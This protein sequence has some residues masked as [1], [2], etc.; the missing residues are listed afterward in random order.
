MNH[1]IT[2]ADIAHRPTDAFRDFLEGEVGRAFRQDRT[3]RR[4]RLA[5][6]ILV[7]LAIGTTAGL[8][9]AQVR[10]G[11]QRDSLL[12]AMRAE[13]ALVSLR[14][15]LSR[16][17]LAEQRRGVAAGTTSSESLT[18]ADLQVRDMESQLGRVALSMDEIKA[19]AK[20]PRDELNAPLVNGR[21]FVKERMQARAMILQPRM[22]AAEVVQA[23][24]A[25]RVRAGVLGETANQEAEL[26]LARAT[27]DLAVLAERLT[28]RKEYLEKGTPVEQ[29]MRRLEQAEL[30]QDV[31]VT[32][33]A[34]EL[35]RDRAATL[36]KRRAVGAG[37]QL[38]V[39]KA[40]V[41]RKERE[42]ELQQLLQRVASV[43]GPERK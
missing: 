8:A 16:A 1:D 10:A 27:R 3:L 29:L 6:V 2:H 26:A 28:L 42:I 37:E 31:A 9:S 39:L 7:S 13:A 43:K 11:S 17:Q 15:E 30:R 14:L 40:Q 21:D 23:E 38:E 5:A 35:A 20:A 22:Q 25:R 24:T 34:L 4:L 36:E 41:E 12:D 19:T 33:R 18:S 32:Q